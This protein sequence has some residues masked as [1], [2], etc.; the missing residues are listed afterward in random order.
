MQT[1]LDRLQNVA[2]TWGYRL[3][4]LRPWYANLAQ[5]TQE[6]GMQPPPGALLKT[7]GSVWGG[8]K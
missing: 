3:L 6:L 8:L 2:E 7:G 5:L 4:F 1:L